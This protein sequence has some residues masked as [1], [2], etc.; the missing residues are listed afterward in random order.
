[1]KRDKKAAVK[2]NKAYEEAVAAGNEDAAAELRTQ[3]LEM[4]KKALDAF[5]ITQDKFFYDSD[6][7]ADYDADDDFLA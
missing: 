3:G 2:C 5:Q 6:F 4:N 1:M 7:T